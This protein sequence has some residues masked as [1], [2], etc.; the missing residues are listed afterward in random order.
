[1][2]ETLHGE[3]LH[4]LDQLQYL[5]L[6]ELF[7]KEIHQENKKNILKGPIYEEGRRIITVSDKLNG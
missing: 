3:L 1:M 2:T 5:S 4:L 6:H 7:V